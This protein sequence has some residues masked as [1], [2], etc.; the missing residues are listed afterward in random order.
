MDETDTKKIVAN[1]RAARIEAE[2]RANLKKRKDQAR[3]RAPG[4]APGDAQPAGRQP[5]DDE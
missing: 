4:V 1:K 2:L 5:D 3:A